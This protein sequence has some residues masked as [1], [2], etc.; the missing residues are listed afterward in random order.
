MAHQMSMGQPA[1]DP[2]KLDYLTTQP[3]HWRHVLRDIKAAL[4]NSDLCV[5]PFERGA[6]RPEWV[7]NR[8]SGENMPPAERGP[9]WDARSGDVKQL[10]DVLA[11][12]GHAPLAINHVHSGLRW[13]P[14]D[15]DHQSVLRAEYQRDL[16][17]LR[18]GGEGMVNYIGGRKTPRFL[19]T[20]A[21]N[22]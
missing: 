15:A 4:P 19:P 18:A 1:P 9:I 3:R 17:W 14:F 22:E 20:K 11:Q 16:T 2:N 12:A 13:M 21:A 7:I 10:N 5:L 8:L 6:G